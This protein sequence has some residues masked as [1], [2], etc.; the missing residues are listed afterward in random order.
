MQTNNYLF[1]LIPNPS[2]KQTSGCI[3][4]DGWMEVIAIVPVLLT[5]SE[6][7]S[8]GNREIGNEVIVRCKE[9]IMRFSYNDLWYAIDEFEEFILAE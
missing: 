8:P 6:E 5:R 9:G 3:P 1:K 2:C 7:G 4:F